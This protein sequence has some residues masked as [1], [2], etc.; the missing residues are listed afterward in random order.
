MSAPKTPSYGGQKFNAGTFVIKTD[1]APADLRAQLDAASKDLGLKVVAVTEMPKTAM[2]DIPAPR[3]ALMHTWTNTQN[4]G[5]Y[6]IAFDQLHIP[7]DYIADQKLKTMT[8]LSVEIRR[9]PIRT[10]RRLGAVDY[11]R[12]SHRHRRSDSIQG[13]DHHAEPGRSSRHH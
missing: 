6:R 12:P 4:E 1:G 7:Y 13:L 2:H 11:E 5:W 9:D 3:I 8:D 10:R